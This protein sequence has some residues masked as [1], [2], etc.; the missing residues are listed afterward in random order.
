[1][2]LPDVIAQ[3]PYNKTASQYDP[4][5]A[6]LQQMLNTEGYRDPSGRPLA[7]DGMMGPLTNYA[8]QQKAA[9]M[10]TGLAGT[11]SVPTNYTIGPGNTI[12]GAK[13]GVFQGFTQFTP[14]SGGT[15][16]SVRN[17]PT[18]V[19]SFNPEIGN[20]LSALHTKASA[21]M[22]SV[23]S[24][25]QYIAAK[26]RLQQEGA[27]A[28]TRA[29][30]GLA[31]RGVL[32]SSMTEDAM[33]RIEAEIVDRLT[34]QIGPGVQQQLLSERQGELGGLRS[35][36]SQAMQLAGMDAS[37]ATSAAQMT[38]QGRQFDIGA[39]FDRAKLEQQLGAS[40]LDNL[41]RSAGL[42]GTIPEGLAGAGGL[43]ADEAYRRKQLANELAR[44]NQ[45]KQVDYAKDI[46]DSLLQGLNAGTL[47]DATLAPWQRELLGLSEQRAEKGVDYVK[48][49]LNMLGKD[50]TFVMLDGVA[51]SER[52][53]EM[54]ALLRT[55]YESDVAPQTGTSPSDADIDELVQKYGYR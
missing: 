48:L 25:P 27:E 17:T 45:P 40:N 55:A 33:K 6:R 39:M 15:A 11:T 30:Q 44:M 46:R 29:V 21:P 52:I 12:V 14:G 7:V 4:T 43:T 49:A 36:L 22:A 34:T 20:L 8:S 28:S 53:R 10:A 1:M 13:D 16:S 31:A 38:E 42:T 5:V 3:N 19:S 26:A 24:T 37:R 41:Y 47:N 32:R 51:Q 23:E 54:V 50:P 9:S 2:P 18:S 35:D